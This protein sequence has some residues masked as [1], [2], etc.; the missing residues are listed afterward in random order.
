MYRKFEKKKTG[1]RNDY[2]NVI[3]IIFTSLILYI[4]HRELDS[5]NTFCFS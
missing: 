4:F 1:F 2:A 5:S 3:L